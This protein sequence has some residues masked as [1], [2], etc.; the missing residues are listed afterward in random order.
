MI[1]Q[2]QSWYYYI[3]AEKMITEHMDKFWKFMH[4]F[5]WQA[6]LLWTHWQQYVSAVTIYMEQWS[7]TEHGIGGKE[8]MVLD[9][10][11]A[12]SE[13]PPYLEWN[14][15]Q[16][17]SKKTSSKQ[18]YWRPAEKL[19]I[20]QLATIAWHKNRHNMWKFSY[21]YAMYVMLLVHHNQATVID[22]RHANL[23]PEV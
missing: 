13:I 19:R 3:L 20:L 8:C 22:R 14:K 2:S 7:K 12:T 18:Y 10:V 4:G 17:N 6:P 5:R 23:D 15:K 1:K 11:N 16:H 9:Y 21:H